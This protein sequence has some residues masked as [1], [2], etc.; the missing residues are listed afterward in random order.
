MAVKKSNE[1]PEAV[2]SRCNKS[3]LKDNLKK[4][5]NLKPFAHQVKLFIVFDF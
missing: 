5:K 1:M 4:D 3:N 2:E